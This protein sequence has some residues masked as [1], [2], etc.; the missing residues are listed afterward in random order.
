[1]KCNNCSE[2]AVYDSKYSGTQLCGKHLK[3]S[4]EKRVR[5][6]I[7][8]QMSLGN[9]HTKIAV[10][11]SGGKDSSVVLYL[12]NKIL[13]ERRNTEI[14]AVTVDEGIEG[15]RNNGLE[16]ASRLCSN[17]GI[18]HRVLSFE[19]EYSTTLDTIVENDPETIPCSHCGPMRR[20]VMNKL[21]EEVNADY[22]VLGI[23]LDDYTQSVL[24]NV[25]RGDYDRMLRMAPHD[26]EKE[27]LVRRALP[28]IRIPEKEVLLYAILSGIEY[29][30]GWC[31]YFKR[32]QRNS[33]REAVEKFEEEFPGS[34][35]AILNFAEKL[36]AAGVQQEVKMKKCRICGNPSSSD[37][38]PVCRKLSA[39]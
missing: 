6:E 11:I 28:L 35:F 38:C 9:E 23:N 4:I 18:E 1:M 22:L 37:I 34:R 10:A 8:K 31:P 33:F 21:A 39:V 24:M 20:T 17:L 2:E 7:R 3:E 30:S 26:T 15:Y 36:R 19:Q 13:K 25:V 27:G 32:A 29:D 14:V 12:L 16:S 5:S